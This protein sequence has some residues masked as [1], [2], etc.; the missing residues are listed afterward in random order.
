MP[1]QFLNRPQ[2]RAVSQQVSRKG[3]PEAMRMDLGI[4]CDRHR[5]VLHDL[6]HSGRS[7]SPAVMIDEHGALS[8]LR[9]PLHE[10]GVHRGSRFAWEG[11]LPLFPTF[12]S[13]PEPAV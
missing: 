9:M 1:Q 13:Y 4:A 5:V 8:I 2:V 6:P 12:A 3:V 7:D 11:N 10:V